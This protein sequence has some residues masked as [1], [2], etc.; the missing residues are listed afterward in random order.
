MPRSSSRSELLND[1]YTPPDKL[2][3]SETGLPWHSHHNQRRQ[4]ACTFQLAPFDLAFA[5]Q[6]LET[7][8]QA[9]EVNG[10]ELLHRDGSRCHFQKNAWMSGADDWETYSVALS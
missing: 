5:K 3:Q 9:Y 7:L 2:L 10:K 4:F 1:A 8:V 6:L